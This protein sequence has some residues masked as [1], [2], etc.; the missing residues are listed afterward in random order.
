MTGSKNIFAIPN[1]YV[2]MSILCM[3][4]IYYTC[5]LY[6]YIYIYIYIYM[7]VCIYCAIEYNQGVEKNL[8]L[9]TAGF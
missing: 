9:K 6:I 3:Y 8:Y 7:C 5:I 4:I 2:S 1:F